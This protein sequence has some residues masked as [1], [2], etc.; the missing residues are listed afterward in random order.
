M[1]I[2]TFVVN[3][4]HFSGISVIIDHHSCITDHRYPANLTWVK[5]AYVNVG[6]N[7]TCKT[8]IE[9]GNIMDMRLKMG[10]RLNFDLFRLFAEYIK[11]NRDIMR[12]EVP[13]YI[14]IAAKQA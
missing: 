2:G 3:L 6:T 9:M 8:Q 13:D 1:H 11:Q 4:D 14:G 7:A 5:P 12:R 10:M